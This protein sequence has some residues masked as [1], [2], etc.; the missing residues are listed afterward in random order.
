MTKKYAVLGKPISHSKSPV[1]HRAAF[2]FLNADSTYDSFELG[3][4]LGLFLES[5]SEYSG[6]SVTMPLKD[7]A[8]RVSYELDDVAQATKSVNTLLHTPDGWQG[9]NTDVFGIQMAVRGFKAEKA[10]VLGAGA[11]A[12][13]AVWALLSL[14]SEVSI[15]GRS[16]D[17]T[18]DL[19]SQ[20]SI[21]FEDNI[22]ETANYDLVIS[23]LPAMALNEFIAQIPEPRGT[24]LD[25]AYQPWPSKAAT[26]WGKQGK[27]I[28]GIEMLLWQAIAQQ[29]L[30]SGI[31][32]GES[33]PNEDELVAAV[34]AALSMAQ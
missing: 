30:F 12:R 10:V 7:E 6:F 2:R 1:I 16:A 27:A 32:K 25:V 17:K 34:R 18:S 33:L 20:Y 15:W 24:L 23:T 14:G 22:A 21:K 5:H 9:H 3:E 31:G 26:H 28:S 19:A 8:F 11:T 4:D 29:R 13:S